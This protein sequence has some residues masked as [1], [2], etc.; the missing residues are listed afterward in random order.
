MPPESPLV[1]HGRWLRAGVF[2]LAMTMLAMTAHLLAGGHLPG[3]G[4]PSSPVSWS[5]A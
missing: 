2:S 3:V 1:T 5:D 4:L